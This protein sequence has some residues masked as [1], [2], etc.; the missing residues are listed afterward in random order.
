MATAFSQALNYL[1]ARNR[2]VHETADYLRRKGYSREET[3]EAVLR[4]LELDLLND[5]KTASQWVE[6]TM[7]CKPRGRDRL[8]RELQ[9][10]GVAREII[11]EVLFILDDDTEY[12]LALALLAGRPVPQWSRGKLFRFLRYRG[13][14]VPVIDRV[15]GYY[16]NLTGE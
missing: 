8:Y 11:E 10:R 2:T 6:Y 13:F 12:E 15:K 16:E 1:T 3:E 4:L 9:A 7:R 14:S 5:R